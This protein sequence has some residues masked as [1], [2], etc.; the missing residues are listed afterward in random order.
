[1]TAAR[2]VERGDVVLVTFP[3]TDLSGQKVRP[4]PVIGKADDLDVILAFVTSRPVETGRKTS[5]YL[6]SNDGEF[7]STGLK[8]SST[9]RLDKIVTLD[10]VLVRR[11]LGNIGSTT[12]RAVN[13]ALMVVFHL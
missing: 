9:I 11:R 2:S 13:D 4:A 5:V 6:D 12:R 7:A 10:R 3:F 1:M 8:V